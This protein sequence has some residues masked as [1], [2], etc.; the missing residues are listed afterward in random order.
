MQFILHAAMLQCDWTIRGE[1]K[2]VFTPQDIGEYK[3]PLTDAFFL[4]N[5][6]ILFAYRIKMSP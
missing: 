3:L 5:V 6:L 4:F 2:L 1:Y